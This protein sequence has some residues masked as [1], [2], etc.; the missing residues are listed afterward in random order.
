MIRYHGTD[1]N[2]VQDICNGKIDPTRGGGELGQGFYVGNLAHQAFAWAWQRYGT[3]YTVIKFDIDDAQ[4]LKLSVK[5]INRQRALEKW[6][7]LKRLNTTQVFQYNKDVVWSPLLGG[8]ISNFYQIKF[9]NSAKKF[10][11][12]TTKSVL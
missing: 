10:I 9:E 4:Y 8:N 5:W 1:K 6:K 3:N 12:S 7:E 2:Y 11:N